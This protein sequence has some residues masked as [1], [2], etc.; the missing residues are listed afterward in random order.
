LTTLAP[1]PSAGGPGTVAATRILVVD[2]NEVELAVLRVVLEAEGFEVET[3]DS[4]FDLS[5]AIK[6]DPPDVILLDIMM[7]ALGGD[8][9]AAILKQHGFSRDIP[10]IL[11]SSKDASELASIATRTGAQGFVSK[12]G[13]FDRLV[14]EVRRVLERR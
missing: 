12:T 10:V 11:H 1:R 3:L 8:R 7:P 4:V 5:I 14:A 9:V 2:D 6:R 13:D